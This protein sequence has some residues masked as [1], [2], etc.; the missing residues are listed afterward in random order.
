M[1][2]LKM[3]YRFKI[4]DD[5][6]RIEALKISATHSYIATAWHRHM[7]VGLI[8]MAHKG[9]QFLLSSSADGELSVYMCKKFGYK[10]VRGSSSHGGPDARIAIKEGL[11]N[12]ISLGIGPDR[13][14]GPHK[15]YKL[16][17]IEMAHSTGA[18]I[19]PLA[20]KA[21]RYWSAN[22]WDKMILPKPFAKIVIRYGRPMIIDPQSTKD[23]YLKLKEIAKAAINFCEVKVEED[24]KDWA[25]L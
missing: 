12:G 4:I 5:E 2:L 16:G 6:N 14:S 22:S 13:P 25:R 8:G 10:L 11:R 9:Y 7:L 15:D 21:D 24:I 23:D 1:Y 18:A 17:T 19:L 20:F 3:S